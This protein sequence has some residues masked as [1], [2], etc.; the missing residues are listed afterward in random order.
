M[1]DK[2][3]IYSIDK[4][5]KARYIADVTLA[6]G[7]IVLPGI[8]VIKTWRV[9]N[10]GERAWPDGVMLAYSSGDV[11]G[12][13]KDNLISAAIPA[14]VAGAE[15]DI[16]VPLIMPE[17]SG[18]YVTYFRLR[19]K[20]GKLFGQRLWA[21]I[22][23]AESV[24]VKGE[25]NL[26]HKDNTSIQLENSQTDIVPISIQPNVIVTVQNL[27]NVWESE[28]Q[29]LANLGFT[30]R[31]ML[32]PLLQEYLKLPTIAGMKPS[33]IGLQKVVANLL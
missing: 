10:D 26:Q 27:D 13:N 2:S 33:P 22:T 24:V 23:I 6:D 14:L 20:G 9:R 16:S 15:A 1:I 32:I 19:T 28:L 4:K 11:L 8:S 31:K 3:M 25:T 5:L 30:D 7:T 17:T 12:G 21:H 18:R 29:I